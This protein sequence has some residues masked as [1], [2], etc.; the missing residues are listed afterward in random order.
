VP[1][2]RG[3]NP[4]REHGVSELPP[5][6]ANSEGAESAQKTAEQAPRSDE[7]AAK[8]A[9]LEEQVKAEQQKYV[10][11]YADFDNYKK[12]VARERDDLLKYGFEKAARDVLQVAD[13][14]Q[15]A[16]DHIPESTDKTLRSGVQMVLDQL[17]QTLQRHGVEAVAS[18]GKPFDPNLQEAVGQQPSESPAGTVIQEH[19]KGYVLHGRL[20][21]PARVVISAGPATQGNGASG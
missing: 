10:Y 16:V 9:K 17:N 3:L 5:N 20:L 4:E 21:R 14:L 1:I 12:R 11:L 7:T 15:R 19:Q 18:A 2:V 6:P 8:I 13:N